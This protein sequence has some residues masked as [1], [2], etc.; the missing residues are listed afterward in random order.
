MTQPRH[1]I[2]HS[3]GHTYQQEDQQEDQQEQEDEEQQ[4]ENV[5]M[6]LTYSP[7][8]EQQVA[9]FPCDICEK[10]FTNEADL[11]GHVK[12]HT[13]VV[14]P[15]SSEVGQLTASGRLLVLTPNFGNRHTKFQQ[16]LN[17]DH[18]DEPDDSSEDN[19]SNDC[20]EACK[21]CKKTFT[22]VSNLQDHIITKHSS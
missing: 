8:K 20:Q 3:V 22:S 16:A 15:S 18:I 21:V 14:S 13:A 17:N 2:P 10:V 12:E 4:Q 11:S 9:C 6:A 7:P 1:D 5:C 19:E